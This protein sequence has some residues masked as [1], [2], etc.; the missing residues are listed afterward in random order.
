M[1]DFPLMDGETYGATLALVR[2]FYSLAAEARWDELAELVTDDFI[3]EEAESLPYG[4]VFRGIDGHRRLM[5]KLF[6]TWEITAFDIE[7]VAVAETH[8]TALM[9][10]AATLRRDG[11]PMT[12][13]I[14]EVLR[15][16]G[17]R[18]RSV[19]PYYS[20]TAAIAGAKPAA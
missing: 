2:R 12:V 17:A 3:V 15:F 10:M 14:C 20:D 16:E 9:T 11:R 19:T 8:A 1:T 6:E 5:E 18:I 13:R 7:G 4:G